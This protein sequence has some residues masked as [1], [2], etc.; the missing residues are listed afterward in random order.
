MSSEQQLYGRLP[1]ALVAPSGDCLQN[2]G[3]HGLVED[4]D[5][6]SLSTKSL[7]WQPSGAESA[8]IDLLRSLSVFVLT[9]RFKPCTYMYTCC[10]VLRD[11]LLC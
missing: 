11:S 4:V 9:L 10:A 1:V 7:G 5:G 3:R 6:S 8:F 2:K